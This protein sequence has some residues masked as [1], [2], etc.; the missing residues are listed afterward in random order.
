MAL[1]RAGAAMMLALV[2]CAG[3]ATAKVLV[4]GAGGMLGRQLLVSL[5]R[6]GY[7]SVAVTRASHGDLAR[8]EGLEA[9]AASCS[10]SG[11]DAVSAVVHCA[12]SFTSEGL[13]ESNVK[14]AENAVRAAAGA[15]AR[16]VLVSS[17]SA[18]RSPAQPPR[19]GVG[20]FTSDDWNE[21]PAVASLGEQYQRSKADSERA[22]MRLAEE[23]GVEM[24]VLCPSMIFGWIDDVHLCR[25]AFSVKRVTAW[26]D[27]E[28]PVESRLAV[29]V[30]DVTNAVIASLETDK[31]VGKRYIVSAEE[32]TPAEEVAKVLRKLTFDRSL[33]ADTDYV[34]P[35]PLGEREVSVGTLVDDLGI[36][37][38]RPGLEA[39]VNMADCIIADEEAEAARKLYGVA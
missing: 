7:G 34:P 3:P 33:E 22:A 12:A 13:L 2:L 20:H 19:E 23:L 39:I 8:P 18:V 14:C 25:D 17:M 6:A 4:T 35:V 37:P 9:L 26:M 27:G 5:G 21:N 16:L 10:G 30:A 31:A 29:D 11:A 24:T 15:G 32:R 28:R 1:H 38:L 36:D